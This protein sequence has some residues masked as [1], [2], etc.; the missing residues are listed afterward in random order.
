MKKQIKTT[1]SYLFNGLVLLRLKKYGRNNYIGKR[2]QVHLPQCVIIGSNVRLGRD[3]RLSC[4]RSSDYPNGGTI[5][6]GDNCYIGDHFSALSGSEIVI[7]NDVLIASYVSVIAENHGMDASSSTKYGL[8]PLDGKPVIIKKGAWIGEK[9]IIL[10]GVTIGEKS[11][12]G[13]GSVV[14]KTVPDYCMAVG[15]PAKIIKKW[16]PNINEWAPI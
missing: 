11:I 7:E 1:L 5:H 3:C 10:Q 2:L 4:Y 8:Q 15:N 12:I 6:I 9:V 16:D 13:S 14:T